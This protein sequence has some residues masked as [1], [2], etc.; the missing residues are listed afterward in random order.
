MKKKIINGILMVAMLF[1]A[2]TSFVSCKD[3]VDDE[4]IPVYAELAKQK[5][6]LAAQITSIQNQI[7]D[8]KAM[9]DQIEKNRVAIQNLEN[10]V[11]GLQSQLDTINN[12]IST[13]SADVDTIKAQLDDMEDDI[14]DLQLAVTALADEILALHEKIDKL[15]TG[16]A[17]NHTLNNVTGSVNLPGGLLKMNA[18]CAFFGSNETGIVQFPNTDEDAVVIGEALTAAEVAPALAVNQEY[19]FDPDTYITQEHGNAGMVF[20]TVNTE[21]PSLF[22]ISEYTLSVRNSVGRTAPIE[23]TDV[24]PSS[25]QIQTGIY[26]SG[27]VDTDED[28]AGDPYLYQARANIARKDLEASKFNLTKFFNPKDFKDKYKAAIDEIK[29]AEGKT[30]KVKAIVLT[31]A[32]FL[33]DIYGDHMS[34]DNKNILNPSWSAQALVLSK[35]VDGETIM[36]RTDDFDLAV[37]AVAPLS[38]NSFWEMEGAFNLDTSALENAIAKLAEKIKQDLGGGSTTTFPVI[39]KISADGMSAYVWATDDNSIAHDAAGAGWVELPQQIVDAINN[40]LQIEDL[41]E[42]LQNASQVAD[43]G[44]KVDNLTARFNSFIERVGNKIVS[45]MHDHML[46][47]G[48][49]PIVLFNTTEGVQRLASGRT[50][51]AGIM[52]INVTSATEELLVP[53]YAKYVALF[54][55]DGNAVQA[56]V[57]NGSEQ[58]FDIDLSKAGQYKLIVSCVDYYGFVINKKY[59]ITVE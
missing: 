2:T 6:D 30:A 41:N 5:N 32:Q 38:Y 55:A 47:R 50:V 36:K 16:I 24:K 14:E 28:L 33:R 7:N 58:R 43:L 9:G 52:Q 59:D 4:L 46:T 12:Q 21:D 27:Y 19:N 42:A 23:F 44:S 1:A 20:F 49:A 10:T 11:D 54:D 13:L 8:M 53:A 39:E 56:N 22:D 3:N 34:G 18:L 25:Y 17:I 26:K 57:Y 35:E 37:S 51:K 15:I 29:A 48:I 45:L 40:G 31:V